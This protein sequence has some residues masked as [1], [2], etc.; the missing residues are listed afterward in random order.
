MLNGAKGA[1]EMKTMK[2][3]GICV[4]G[5]TL[6]LLV[7]ATLAVPVSA[8]T[9]EFNMWVEDPGAPGVKI[10]DLTTLAVGDYNLVVQAKVLNNLTP[11][12]YIVPTTGTPKTGSYDVYGGLQQYGFS[13]VDSTGIGAASSLNFADDGGGLWA[14]TAGPKATGYG[15]NPGQLN[16][17]ALI[18][19][20]PVGDFDV[21]VQSGSVSSISAALAGTAGAYGGWRVAYTGFSTTTGLGGTAGPAPTEAARTFTLVTGG[22]HYSGGYA[23]LSMD[24]N[25]GLVGQNVAF[26]AGTSGATW[27]APKVAAAGVTAAATLAFGT[28]G[29]QELYDTQAQ[30][31]LDA[32][33]G[34]L[35]LPTSWHHTIHGGWWNEDPTAWIALDATGAGS[36]AKYEWTIVDN[37]GSGGGSGS[38]YTFDTT[39][40]ITSVSVQQLMDHGFAT[41][42]KPENNNGMWTFADISLTVFDASNNY[43]HSGVAPL[44]LPEPASLVVLALGAVGALLRRRRK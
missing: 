35:A 20:V 13:L 40:A 8:A 27:T 1:V 10:T 21:L 22:F 28:Q 37:G 34:E 2:K 29:G 7:L 15:A 12:R 14:A 44:I 9:V 33:K 24:L 19:G 42:P 36:F 16:T 5:L 26:N 38:S 6:P 11:N 4:L 39:D 18:S 25:P 43:G 32:H 17:T 30:A 23:Q 41:P 3:A 31:G